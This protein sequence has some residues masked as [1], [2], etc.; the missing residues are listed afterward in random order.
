MACSPLL[1]KA[2]GFFVF[3]NSALEEKENK[4][5]NKINLIKI[6]KKLSDVIKIKSYLFKLI[7]YVFHIQMIV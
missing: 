7:I 2:L 6:K 3:I 4:N 5:K 1:H